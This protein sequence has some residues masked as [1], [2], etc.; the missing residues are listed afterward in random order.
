[1][2]IC[3]IIVSILSIS[4]MVSSWL[5]S[6]A[7][8]PPV[9]I[10]AVIMSKFRSSIFPLNSITVLDVGDWAVLLRARKARDRHSRKGHCDRHQGGAKFLHNENPLSSKEL[11]NIKGS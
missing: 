5:V 8:M 2:P 3:N 6:V 1:M 11:Q 4:M 9:C 7:M 10:V